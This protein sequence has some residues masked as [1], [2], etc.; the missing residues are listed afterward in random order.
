MTKITF[1]GT[2]EAFAPSIDT[3]KYG[4]GKST[5]SYL[6]EPHYPGSKSIM[7]DAGYSAVASLS[8]LL[9]NHGRTFADV[10]DVFLLTH[11]HGDHYGG[12]PALLMKIWE[13]VNGIVGSDKRGK[14]RELEIVSANQRILPKNIDQMVRQATVLENPLE[15]MTWLS[16]EEDYEGFFERFKSQGPTLSYKML[17]PSGDFIG[18]GLSKVN[19]TSAP[20]KHGAPNMAY[21]FDKE[22][23][24]AIS[25]D[26]SLTDESKKL[27][28]GVDLLI[29]EGFDILK[30]SYG[31]NHASVKD[32]VNYAI[33]AGI[34]SIA[35]VHVN[36]QE[37]MKIQEIK[38]EIIRAKKNKVSLVF[39]E[40]HWS[41][42]VYEDTKG[43]LFFD[44]T[45]APY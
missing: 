25:G 21:R 4:R 6:I 17:N 39:P 20:T 12:F 31:T 10:P 22:G 18:E 16:M 26:G 24:F 5:T 9:A 29:H 3:G 40:D 23:S 44:E 7:V 27:F 42:D 19:I 41:A 13:E 28:E 37:R 15:R 33:E 30:D 35:I 2:G 38:N 43:A 45:T 8:S 11:G 34:P 1:L 14:E 32:V 36:R